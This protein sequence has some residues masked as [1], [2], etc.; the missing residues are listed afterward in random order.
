VPALI[1]QSVSVREWEDDPTSPSRR[2][3]SVLH[4]RLKAAIA[5]APP[6]GGPA[7]PDTAV[8]TVIRDT[9]QASERDRG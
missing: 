5:S 4:Y 2:V 7:R 1:T 9:R 3:G 6:A 8:R